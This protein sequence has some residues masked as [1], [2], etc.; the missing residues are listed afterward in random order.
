MRL[1]ILLQLILGSTALYAAPQLS[2][3][4]DILKSPPPAVRELQAELKELEAERGATRAIRL[5]IRNKEKEIKTAELAYADAKEACLSLLAEVKESGDINRKDF[6]GRTLLMLAAATGHDQAT[7]LV[8]QHSPQLDVADEEGL[9]ACDYE[10]QGKGNVLRQQ[11]REQW[12]PALIGG[13]YAMV[14]YLL[15]CGADANWPGDNNIHPLLIAVEQKN[16]SLFSLLLTYGASPETRLD[17]GRKLIE[18]AIEQRQTNTLA[19][20]LAR[21][22]TLPDRLAD[23]RSLLEHLTADDAAD[24]L[25]VWLRHIDEQERISALCQLVRLAPEAAVRT[26]CTEFRSE[27]NKED[28]QGNIP[29]HEAARRAHPG[30]YRCLVELGAAP[31]GR[32][33]RQETTLMHA[34]L[35]GSPDMLSTVLSSFPKEDLQATDENGQN[36]L[37]YANLAKDKT[38]ADTLRAAGIANSKRKR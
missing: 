7:E 22:G 10:L 18:L 34:A 17:D 20:L 2:E 14:Q 24:C 9:T 36:A 32:N 21:G 37:D 16:S 30:I 13:D 5:A 1:Y 25:L 38:A 27:L 23:G 4:A 28:A 33:M 8:L 29:L 26:A 19:E 31:L 3:L 6:N 15:N 35:S 11:L 12:Q